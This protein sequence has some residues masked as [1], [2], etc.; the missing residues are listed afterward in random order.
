MSNDMSAEQ[1]YAQAIEALRDQLPD[2]DDVRDLFDDLD[3]AL[4]EALS[5]QYWAGRRHVV[6]RFLAELQG[7]PMSDDD[8][9]PGPA[10]AGGVGVMRFQVIAGGLDAE[11]A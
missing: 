4:G 8:D 5:E 1:R 10:P 6:E 11:A 9:D 2:T 7:P 3:G